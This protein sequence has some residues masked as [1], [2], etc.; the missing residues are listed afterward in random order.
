MTLLH[1]LLWHFFSLFKKISFQSS[2]KF[3]Q[4]VLPLGKQV[5]DFRHYRRQLSHLIGAK[6]ASRIISKGLFSISMGTN[7]FV[8]N[9][10]TN[11]T[12]R[13]KTTVAQFQDL[14]LRSLAK[15]IKVMI[16]LENTVN[17]NLLWKWIPLRKHW[18]HIDL[19][20]K[21]TKSVITWWRRLSTMQQSNDWEATAWM[22]T[23]I[24]IPH[25]IPCTIHGVTVSIPHTSPFHIKWYA[26]SKIESNKLS[27]RLIRFDML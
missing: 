20:N 11:S 26:L 27:T 9:Y 23:Y 25:T 3:V 21:F 13:E 24:S 19:L 17:F 10:Y 1:S 8:N 16:M 12:L 14:L 5:D 2:S 15:F 22:K 7:D 6:N 18:L 4:D